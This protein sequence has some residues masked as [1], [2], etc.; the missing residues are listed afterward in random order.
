MKLNWYDLVYVYMV[1]L[2]TFVNGLLLF[3][4]K[5]SMNE[6]VYTSD[7][8]ISVEPMAIACQLFDNSVWNGISQFY[9]GQSTSHLI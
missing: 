8:L 1:T 6:Y 3:R 9:W 2:A 5:K 7:V 4:S